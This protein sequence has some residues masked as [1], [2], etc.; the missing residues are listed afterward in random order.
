MRVADFDAVKARLSAWWEGDAP[1][2]PCIA[3][4]FLDTKSNIPSSKDLN[5]FWTDQDFIIRRTTASIDNTTYI[6]EAVPFHYVDQGSSAGSGV[7]GARMEYIDQETIW[8]YPTVDRLEEILECSLSP[9]NAYYKRIIEITQRST[10]HARDHHF[11]SH[12]ALGG[13]LDNLAG[14]GAIPHLDALLEIDNIRAIQWVP[15]AGKEELKQW[16]ELLQK[17]LAAGKSCQVFARPDEDR[18]PPTRAWE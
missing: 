11:V 12:Y 14:V 10:R 1:E 6:G 16:Y 7:I 2:S 9:P 3:A 4:Q 17:I 18:R 5:T 15:G 8:A 13:L